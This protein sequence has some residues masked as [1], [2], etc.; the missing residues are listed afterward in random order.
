MFQCLKESGGV[1][2][3]DLLDFSRLQ[4]GTSFEDPSTSRG[5][6]AAVSTFLMGGGF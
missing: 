4:T 2:R 1:R 6:Q 3:Q 5:R